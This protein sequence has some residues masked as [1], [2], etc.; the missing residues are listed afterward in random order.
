[1]TAG[2]RSSE[3][4][5]ELNMEIISGRLAASMRQAHMSVIQKDR[6]W[7]LVIWAF[8]SPISVVAKR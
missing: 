7:S 6:G 8:F 4:T 2:K 5:K 1:M 3:D